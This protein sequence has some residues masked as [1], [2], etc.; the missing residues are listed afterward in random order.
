MEKFGGRAVMGW[1]FFQEGF[2][3]TQRPRNAV[4]CWH[5]SHVELSGK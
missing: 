5:F 2:R 4:G 3:E 1:F